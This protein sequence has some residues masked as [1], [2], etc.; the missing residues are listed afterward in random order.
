MASFVYGKEKAR[1]IPNWQM[2]PDCYLTAQLTL[3][4]GYE[5]VFDASQ[6]GKEITKPK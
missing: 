5:K 6:E 4:T 2:Q 1:P 3:V